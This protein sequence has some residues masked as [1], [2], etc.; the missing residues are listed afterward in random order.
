MPARW[1]KQTS[2]QASLRPHGGGSVMP[3]WMAA[4]EQKYSCRIDGTNGALDL[5]F[6]CHS[7]PELWRHKGGENVFRTGAITAHGSDRDEIRSQFAALKI[8]ARK[9]LWVRVPC[10]PL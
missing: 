1:R 2:S 8:V 4:R 10:P 3:A 9:G 5:P 7:P 6:S